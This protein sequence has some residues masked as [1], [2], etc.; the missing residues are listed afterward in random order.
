MKE[1]FTKPLMAPPSH[2]IQDENHKLLLSHDTITNPFPLLDSLPPSFESFVEETGGVAS[3]G[4]QKLSPSSEGSLE[5]WPLVVFRIF[6]T[7]RMLDSPEMECSSENQRF[8]AVTHPPEE[9]AD[10][11]LLIPLKGLPR[12]GGFPMIPKGSQAVPLDLWSEMM[13]ATRDL[14]RELED[15]ED[16]LEEEGVGE[17]SQA[18]CCSKLPMFGFERIFLPEGK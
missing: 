5:E 11:R 15:R 18:L 13:M 9:D 16:L 6:P 8:L 14:K 3:P 10:C 17:S 7:E 1:R 4:Q 12:H 2:F